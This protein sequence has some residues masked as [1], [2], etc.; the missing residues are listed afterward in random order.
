MIQKQFS[1]KLTNVIIN[2]FQFK[3]KDIQ[4]LKYYKNISFDKIHNSQFSFSL[5]P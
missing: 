3:N 2:K 5:V 1:T 4:F